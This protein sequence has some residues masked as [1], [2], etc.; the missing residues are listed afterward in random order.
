M[1]LNNILI[2]NIKWPYELHPEL[3]KE[4]FSIARFTSD[5]KDIGL[6]TGKIK[7]NSIAYIV[8]G[9]ASISI[10]NLEMKS[11]YGTTIKKDDWFGALAISALDGPIAIINE[12]SPVSIIYFPKHEIM[13]VAAQNEQV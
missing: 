10:P 7:L 9:L 5:I 4:L 13:R 12:L 1:H 8:D 6:K 11:L 2:K 3:K